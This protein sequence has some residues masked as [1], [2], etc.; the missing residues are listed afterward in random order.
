MSFLVTIL[1]LCLLF[2]IVPLSSSLP[3]SG[4]DGG[5][6][7]PAPPTTTNG[8]FQ[9]SRTVCLSLRKTT[10]HSNQATWWGRTNRQR[11]TTTS[12]LEVRSARNGY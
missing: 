5:A 6:T 7:P 1:C 10:C 11:A 3:A 8:S 4:A 9:P 12:L 2:K